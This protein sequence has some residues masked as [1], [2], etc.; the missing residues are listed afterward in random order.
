LKAEW[1]T[2]ARVL[3][4]DGYHTAAATTAARWARAAGS[5]VVADLDVLHP[6]LDTLLPLIDYPIVSRDFP[7]RLTGISDLREA[8]AMMH[9]TYGSTLTAATLGAEGVIAWDGTTLH[10]VTSYRVPVVD[11]T[12][13]GDI[14]HAG[15]I[16]GLLQEDWTLT[17]RLEFACAAAA[18]NCTA[19]GARGRIG[20]LE[21]IA[22]L[23]SVS[24][25]I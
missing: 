24:P 21:E 17:E 3:H 7:E 23:R 10:H 11:T 22:A 13:A 12:G 25:R 15:F 1:I 4:V 9:S 14:F 2:T 18:L 16:Y 5:P 19:V 20:S 8:L 6:G